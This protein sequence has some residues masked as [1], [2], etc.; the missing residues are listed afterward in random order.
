M[1]NWSEQPLMSRRQYLQTS[2]VAVA[3][4]SISLAAEAKEPGLIDAHVHVW[5]PDTKA[6]PLGKDYDKS[7]MKPASFTPDELF[8]ECRPVGVDRIVLIQMSFYQFDNRYMLD[9]IAK[10]PGVFRGV[11]IVDHD[12]PNVGETMRELQ[13]QGVSGFRLYADAK[14]THAWLSSPEMATMWKEAADTGQAICLLANPDALPDIEKLCRRFPKTK[15]VVDHFSR[16]GV[17][18]TI[19]PQ[20]LANLCKLA[21]FPLTHVK[22]SAFYALGKKQPPYLDLAPM[23]ERLRDTFGPQRLM[24]ASDCP[25]QVQDK[26][27]YAASISLIREKLSFLTAEDKEWMLRKTAQSVFWS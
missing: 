20:D 3:G 15:V 22:T 21:S 1:S 27:S 8:A 9:Q 11:A 2:A 14:S 12:K 10:Y 13:E 24:W 7:A 6:Y 4:A 25:Y 17:S 18:G 16:I 26:H 23:V 5:T 19:E